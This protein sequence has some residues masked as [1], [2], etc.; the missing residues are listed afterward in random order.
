VCHFET[1]FSVPRQP[2][3]M[4]KTIWKQ[5]LPE[6][7]QKAFFCPVHGSDRRMTQTLHVHHNSIDMYT[8]TQKNNRRLILQTGLGTAVKVAPGLQT[9]DAI[10]QTVQSSDLRSTQ[11][12]TVRPQ[13]HSPS[14]GPQLRQWLMDLFIII[15]IIIIKN[16]TKLQKCRKDKSRSR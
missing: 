16:R 3:L 8:L 5:F 1:N 12:A 9:A 11:C 13:L 10:R 15:I 2:L 14:R 4:S 6:H 7:L